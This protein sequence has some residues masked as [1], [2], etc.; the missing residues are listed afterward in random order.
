MFGLGGSFVYDRCDRCRSLTL[1]TLPTDLTPYYP[2]DYYSFAR[3]GHL[4]PMTRLALRTLLFR[5]GGRALAP[6]APGRYRAVA[7]TGLTRNARVLDVGGG[8]GKL[9]DEL[10]L[11]G[12]LG[13]CTVF[14]PF[15]SADRTPGGAT[16]VRGSMND[17]DG[18]FDLV[19]FNHSLEHHPDPRAALQ[20]AAARLRPRG[21]LVVRTPTVSSECWERYGV[22]WV[23]LDAPRHLSIPSEFALHDLLDR[24]GLRVERSWRDGEAFQL[25]GSELYRRDL[26]YAG[27]RPSDAFTRWER[28]NFA[29]ETARLNWTGRSGRIAIIARPLADRYTSAGESDVTPN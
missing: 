12:L 9:V 23:E 24:V 10:R 28:L 20:E 5:P 2:R 19:M 15:A 7:R 29:G 14:D 4:T 6:I 8:D 13:E 16:I 21:H 26:P 11:A 18:T 1:R 17:V 25:W 3:P 22:D 27:T